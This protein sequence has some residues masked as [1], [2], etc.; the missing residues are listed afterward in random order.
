[1][2]EPKQ[3][4]CALQGIAANKKEHNNFGEW[5]RAVSPIVPFSRTHLEDE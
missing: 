4:T 5:E 2:K 1:M 3:R